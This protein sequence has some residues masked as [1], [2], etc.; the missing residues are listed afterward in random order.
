MTISR[1]T[2]L[3][4]A[5]DRAM[6]NAPYLLL[7]GALCAAAVLM[8]AL[9]APLTFFGDS[10]AV[11]L[12]RRELTPETVLAPHNEHIIAVPVLLQNLFVSV[13]GMSSARPEQVAM[14]ICLLVIACLLFVYIRRRVGPWVALLGTS[15]LLF[16]GPAWEAI[17][18]PFEIGL[19]GSILF[20]IAMLL[21]L[22]RDDDR[23]DVVACACLTAAVFS[24]SLGL[25]FVVAAAVDLLQK[26]RSRD[27][28]RRLFVVAVPLLLFAV[29]YVG[30]G[31]EAETHLSLRNV[32]ASP[33]FV[34]EMVAFAAAGT[35]GLGTS[36]GAPVAG[37]GWGYAVVIALAIGLGYR[38]ASRPDRLPAAFWPVATAAATSWFLTAFNQVPGREPTSSRYAYAG[39]V[40]LLMMAANA[41]RGTRLGPRA[42]TVM[43]A[44][45]LAA[46]SVNTVVMKDGQNW[47]RDH[48]VLTRADLA[49]IEIA[50]STVSPDFQLNPEIAGTP[51]LLNVTA[52]EY[53]EA[54]DEH[55]SPAYD[56]EELLNAPEAG[57]RQADIVLASALPLSTETLAG[58]A[59]PGGSC[60]A[61]DAAAAGSEVRLS[62]G[63]TTIALAPGPAATMSLRRFATG[64]FPV[65][66][67]DLPGGSTTRLTIPPDASPVPWHLLITAGQPVRVCGPAG[68]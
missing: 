26:R 5:M 68:S 62:R 9:M 42:L 40:F 18:W 33:R 8:L 31:S 49:A 38:L 48:T 64:E 14:T 60:T 34:A 27:L 28:L 35:V 44:V 45:V 56:E 37:P 3:P 16:L 29:W 10:W 54:V 53:L 15:L 47:L 39:A 51:T 6:R 41:M 1:G 21:A 17:L 66:T 7:A 43:G 25:P 61:I 23:G 36:P 52:G 13:F 12:G 63:A 67:M 58:P 4:A 46:I 57:R 65:T 50:R 2:R 32:L 24:S 59:P 22:D 55:G 11:L 30:W 19:A 20:G